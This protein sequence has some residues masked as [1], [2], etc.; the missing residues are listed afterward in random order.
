MIDW[1]P[2]EP[3]TPVSI[4]SHPP[5]GQPGRVLLSQMSEAQKKANGST[6]GLFHS[7]LLPLVRASHKVEPSVKGQP[8]MGGHCKVTQQRTKDIAQGG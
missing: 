7:R 6:H 4:A 3:L 8:R 1:P 2:L 5:A